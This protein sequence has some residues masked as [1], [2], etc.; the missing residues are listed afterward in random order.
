MFPI[1]TIMIFVKQI[2]ISFKSNVTMAGISET[3]KVYVQQWLLVKD[4]VDID[5]T[6]DSNVVIVLH[7][8]TTK[9]LASTN[10]FWES[11]STDC[12]RLQD[13]VL[14]TRVFFFFFWL[15]SH[16]FVTCRA[17]R[18]FHWNPYVVVRQLQ[19]ENH[20]IL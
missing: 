13:A 18:K 4:I 1:W 17:L 3:I 20:F 10:L 15:F 2:E 12:G 11:E 8:M 14:S 19:I 5:L 6:N 9:W 7:I 16:A